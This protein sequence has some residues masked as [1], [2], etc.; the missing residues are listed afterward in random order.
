MLSCPICGRK[1]SGLLYLKK[2]FK[3]HKLDRCPICGKNTGLIYHAYQMFYYHGCEAHAVLWV[4]LSN[5]NNKNSLKHKDKYK[6][7]REI[8]IKKLSE[9]FR[10]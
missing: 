4:L 7:A 6:R 5:R 10:F 1:C 2:H 8:T 9:G 3:T